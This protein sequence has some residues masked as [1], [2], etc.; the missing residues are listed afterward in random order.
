MNLS[1]VTTEVTASKAARII[2]QLVVPP[3]ELRSLSK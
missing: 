3:G 1:T 2:A